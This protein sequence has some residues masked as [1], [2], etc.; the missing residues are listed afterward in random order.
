[1]ARQFHSWIVGW[2]VTRQAQFFT[3]VSWQE[4]FSCRVTAPDVDSMSSRITR[5]CGECGKEF[6]TV[7]SRNNK[8]CSVQCGDGIKHRFFPQIVPCLNGC[9]IWNGITNRGG[10]GIIELIHNG[11]LEQ[12]AHRISWILHRGEIPESLQVLHHCDNPP[13]VNPDHLFIGTNLDNIRD[14]TE[15]GRNN[16]V[17]IRRRRALD[18]IK[19]N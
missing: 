2:P 15:K 4:I 19:R 18:G 16:A 3:S 11:K 17:R 14:K 1:M 7:P 9:W 6:Q 5:I 13:C 10:Y 8:F 12:Y